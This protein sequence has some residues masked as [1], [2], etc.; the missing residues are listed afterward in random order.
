MKIK[1]WILAAV[2]LL[3][4]ASMA[5]LTFFARELRDAALPHVTAY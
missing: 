1:T 5:M 4:F 3:F 2:T